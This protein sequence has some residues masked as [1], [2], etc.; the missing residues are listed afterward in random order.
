MDRLLIL[1]SSVHAVQGFKDLLGYLK[2]VA[3]KVTPP[4]PQPS[5]SFFTHCLFTSMCHP[6]S[7]SAVVANELCDVRGGGDTPPLAVDSGA[8]H[9]QPPP[10]PHNAANPNP[11]TSLVGVSEEPSGTADTGQR[12]RSGDSTTAL[13]TI[14]GCHS[15]IPALQ[16]PKLAIMGHLESC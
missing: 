16:T 10:P 5:L 7:C 9:F 2:N 6:I 4:S 3:S 11:L 14:W 1:F 13:K 12:M 15:F 8:F